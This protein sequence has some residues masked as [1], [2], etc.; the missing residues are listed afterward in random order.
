MMKQKSFW[1]ILSISGALGILLYFAHVFIGGA[2]WQGYNPITQ[3]ISE[4]TGTGAPNADF[5][6]VLTTAYGILV[7]FFSFC[8]YFIFK[9]WQLHK[10][11]KIGALLLIIM[12]ATSLLGYGLFPLDMSQSTASFQ[13]LMHIVVTVVVVVTTL[14][15]VYFI[16]IGLKKSPGHRKLGVFVLIC[17]VIITAS[18]LMTPVSMANN[19]PISGL[20]ERINIFTLQI[21]LLVASIYLFS[22]KVNTVPIANK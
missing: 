7:V 12:E 3:T 22:K 19:L 14:G 20:V 2:L 8:M 16:A 1:Q 15:S 21:S 5:L 17:A 13:N 6:R 11:A 4:L 10:A 9:N 18:G